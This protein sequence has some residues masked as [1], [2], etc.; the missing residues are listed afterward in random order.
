MEVYKEL[1]NNLIGGQVER[2]R[3]IVGGLL[4]GGHDPREIISGGLLAGMAVVG[5][6]F[7]E[8]DLF[9]PEVLLSA[10]CMH[11]AM[12]LLKPLVVGETGISK[13][14]FMIGTVEDDLH[15][16]GKNLV[17]MLLESRGFTVLD[18][19]INV[20]AAGFVAAVEREKPDILGLSA[21]L[22]TTLHR[23][24]E[25][26]RALEK[27]GLRDKVQ[28]MVGGAPVTRELADSIGAD[29]YAPDAPTAADKALELLKIK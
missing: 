2:V 25:V 16:I 26:I 3:E 14:K 7:K 5:K 18:L 9:I 23:M 15:D 22:T 6:R 11:S 21:L 17:V 10:R 1:Q 19:G 29:G 20:K 13:G 12:D 24:G 8:G 28:V 27:A 4:D